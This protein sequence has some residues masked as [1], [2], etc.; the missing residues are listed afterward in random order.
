MGSDVTTAAILSP[1]NA[2]QLI[3]A[4]LNGCIM[5]WDFLDASLLQVIDLGQP[6]THLCAHESFKDSVFV[7]VIRPPKENKTGTCLF[8]FVWNSSYLA[9]DRG[10]G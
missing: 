6:V 3:T 4:S 8:V 9:I 5:V 7:G 2:F 1:H 10:L